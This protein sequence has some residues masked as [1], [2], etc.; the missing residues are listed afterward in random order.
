M[1]LPKFSDFKTTPD[2]KKMWITP[3]PE[4]LVIPLST[5]HYQYFADPAIAARY[6]VEYGAEDP[7]R[8][9]ALRVGFV[10]VNYEINHAKVTVETMRWNRVL[11]KLIDSLLFENEDS[12]DSVWIHTMNEKGYAT[13]VGCTSFQEHRRAGR[14]INRLTLGSWNNFGITRLP[15]PQN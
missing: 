7:T 11:R 8:L 4:N 10:R 2:S 9:A 5:F 12:I 15:P 3:E 1:S 13:Q 6:G 14:P